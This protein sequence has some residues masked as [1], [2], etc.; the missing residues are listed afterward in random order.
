MANEAVPFK[1]PGETISAE[2]VT[3]AVTGKRFVKIGANRQGGGAGGLS[4]DLTNLPSVT[5]CGAGERALGVADKDAAVGAL[6]GVLTGGV[7]PVTAGGTIT[8][9]AKVMSN[10]TGQAV[11]WTSAASEANNSLGI[12]LADVTNGNTAEILLNVS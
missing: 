1:R 5:V 4:T 9:G 6:V 2:V 3:G 12:A 11:A 10:A 8:A 7:V